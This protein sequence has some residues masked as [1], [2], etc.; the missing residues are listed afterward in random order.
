MI[1]RKFVEAKR[2]KHVLQEVN[3][4]KDLPFRQ[5]AIHR[6]VPSRFPRPNKT[7]ISPLF[8][9]VEV[10]KGII[11]RHYYQVPSEVLSPH[12]SRLGTSPV[13]AIIQLSKLPQSFQLFLLRLIFRCHL[14]VVF[15]GWWL[16][17]RREKLLRF[18]PCLCP[19]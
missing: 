4:S 15:S 11:T 3:H 2:I 16:A 5:N 8:L 17:D 13:W 6:S 9:I 1:L 12:S 14:T 18:L 7:S 19:F 10:S